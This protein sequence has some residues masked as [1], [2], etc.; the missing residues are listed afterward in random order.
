M[1]DETPTP[2]P[3]AAPPAPAP[4]K[5]RGI[6]RWTLRLLLIIFVPLILGV[7]IVLYAVTTERGTRILLGRFSGF[8]PGQL[9]VGAQRGPLTGPLDLR[10]V[11]YKT[12]TMDL[13]IGHVALAW[14][15]R[16][17]S[18]RQLDVESLHAEKI[19]VV[20]PPSKTEPSDGKL[21]DIHLPVNIVV[22]DALIRDVEI[23]HP[24]QPSFR[25]DQ[26]ALDA[27]SDRL[28]DILHVRS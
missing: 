18:G 26:I 17:L 8:I 15:L 28:R 24:G 5:R 13:Q 10:D 2:T 19:R 1:S 25:L 27:Q 14:N 7:A 12:D 23:S 4:K 22:R 16:K 3:M 21:V 20:L 6:L 11:H 9:T